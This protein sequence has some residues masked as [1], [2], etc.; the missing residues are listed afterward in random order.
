MIVKDC[1]E[2]FLASVL[3]RRFVLIAVR[4]IPGSRRRSL[5]RKEFRVGVPDLHPAADVGSQLLD[6]VVMAALE[7]V[8]GDEGEEPLDLVDPAGIRW[9]EVH[10]EPGGERPAMFSRGDSHRTV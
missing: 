4:G 2:I 6:A 10:L 7:H 5:P 9:G 8:L 1:L 3:R